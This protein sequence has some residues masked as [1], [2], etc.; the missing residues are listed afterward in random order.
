MSAKSLIRSHTRRAIACPS[1]FEH[2][3]LFVETDVATRWLSMDEASQIVGEWCAGLFT[4]RPTCYGRVIE[5]DGLV[6][7]IDFRDD[8]DIMR[9]G[10]RNIRPCHLQISCVLAS[11]ICLQATLAGPWELPDRLRSDFSL[12]EKR[13]TWA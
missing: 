11:L 3:N 7:A 4:N 10:M 2:F 6:L 12:S 1:S 8:V 5:R 13:W 9:L